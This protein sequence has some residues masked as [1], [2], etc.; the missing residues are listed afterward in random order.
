MR[1]RRAEVG[2]PF[3]VPHLRGQ[4]LELAPPDVFEQLSSRGHGGLLVQVDR[5]TE[6]C[7]DRLPDRSSEVDA[8]GHRCGVEGYKR[9]DVN[10]ADPRVLAPMRAQVDLCRRNG[11]EAEEALGQGPRVP[12][13]GQDR[14]IVRR[15]GRAIEQ[16]RAGNVTGGIRELPDDL[17]ST[18]FADVGNGLDHR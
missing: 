5:N 12:H 6:P 18:A 14:A 7:G 1:R 10:H 15:I 16:A 8:G 9:H 4:A 11:E 17:G 13:D 3:L 2:S